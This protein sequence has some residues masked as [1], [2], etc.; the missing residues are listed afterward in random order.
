MYG[1][2]WGPAAGHACVCAAGCA[3]LPALLP[4]RERLNPHVP[5]LMCR[6]T[7][8][9]QR[10]TRRHQASAC[11]GNSPLSLSGSCRQMC[12]AYTSSSACNDVWQPRKTVEASARGAPECAACGAFHTAA[13]SPPHRCQ[14]L[15]GG[16]ANAHPRV[17]TLVHAA[18]GLACSGARLSLWVQ[19]QRPGYCCTALLRSPPCRQEAEHSAMLCECEQAG[20]HDLRRAREY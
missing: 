1:C 3:V 5:A 14:W 6:R 18:K 13:P 20:A 2:G 4:M 7:S 17:W 15:P 10:S 16:S 11:A 12:G 19:L 8:L 9:E